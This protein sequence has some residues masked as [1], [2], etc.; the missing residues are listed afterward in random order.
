MDSMTNLEDDFHNK[1]EHPLAFE[2]SCTY[3][4]LAFYQL[5]YSYS[6]NY[7]YVAVKACVNKE[8]PVDHVMVKEL[9]VVVA[10][11]KA[12]LRFQ[13]FSCNRS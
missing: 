12:E 9:M 8:M 7:D 11:L 13:A 1:I 5:I 10:T 3:L 2:W 4:Y 6:Q